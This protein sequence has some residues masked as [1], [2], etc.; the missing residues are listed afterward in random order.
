MTSEDVIEKHVARHFK[1]LG[2]VTKRQH[3]IQIGSNTGRADVVIYKPF[4]L[5]SDPLD[6]IAVIVECKAEKKVGHG[7]DQLYNDLC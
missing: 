4:A 2:F 5:F 6:Q 7:V 1:K 3:T